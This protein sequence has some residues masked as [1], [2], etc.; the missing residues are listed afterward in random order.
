[1]CGSD[2]HEIDLALK[3]ALKRYGHNLYEENI[4]PIF[5][6]YDDRVK[7]S[8]IRARKR[9]LNARIESGKETP[10]MRR[11]LT[12]TVNKYEKILEDAQ[13]LNT[14]TPPSSSAEDESESEESRSSKGRGVRTLQEPLISK[15]W[16]SKGR[17]ARTQQEPFISK[18]WSSKGRGVRTQQ[19]HPFFPSLRKQF[20]PTMTPPS[21]STEDE[22][23]S[24]LSKCSKEQ[25]VRSQQGSKSSLPLE[26]SCGIKMKQSGSCSLSQSS[27]KDSYESVAEVPMVGKVD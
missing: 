23:D 19:E 7:Y 3:D 24:E 5:A 9:G 6:L 16:S 2:L 4:L 18:S 12:R 17:G 20:E 8:K 26:F 11:I 13:E 15:S 25:N 22:S 14:M 21:S 10:I 1:M 27:A